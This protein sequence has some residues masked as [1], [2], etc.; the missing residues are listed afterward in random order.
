LSNV[1]QN[2]GKSILVAAA[3]GAAV[4]AGV[5]LLL[6]PR[7]GKD[8]RAWLAQRTREMK[9]KTTSAF[10]QGKDA[11]IRASK[12]IGRDGDT[13]AATMRSRTI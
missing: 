9:D 6:A 1:N 11:V 5:A 8:T 2:N 12:E 7:S 4:G 3:V 10:E 13:D